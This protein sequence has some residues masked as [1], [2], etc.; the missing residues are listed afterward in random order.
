MPEETPEQ[1][2]LGIVEDRDM[3]VCAD[4]W[5]TNGPVPTEEICP[6]CDRCEDCCPCIVCSSCSDRT[7]NYCEECNHC[8]DCCDCN[9]CNDCGRTQNSVCSGCDR[10]DGCGCEC[11]EES[12]G[13]SLIDGRL[14]FHAARKDQYKLN[15]SKRFISLE[16]E[17]SEGDGQSVHDTCMKYSDAIV[18]DGSLP[19]SGWELNMNPSQGD[20]FVEHCNDIAKG[21]KIGEACVDSSCGMHCHVDARDYGWFDLFKLIKLYSIVENG[22]FSIVSPSRKQGQYSKPCRDLFSSCSNF[23]TFKVDLMSALYDYSV[24]V[25]GKRKSQDGNSHIYFTNYNS[26]K[27]HK[28]S[29]GSP[30]V[31]AARS[32]KYNGAR[33]SALNIHSYFYRGTIE[34]RHHQGTTQASKMIH[35]GRICAAVIDSATKMSLKEI[36]NLNELTSFDALLSILSDD[37]KTWAMPRKKD[38][39]AVR[40]S[41][42]RGE[43]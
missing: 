5:H 39:E 3:S 40:G 36:A 9:H 12:N 37:L 1:L 23:K 29:H 19:D 28:N 8:N 26:G 13:D 2:E 20:V 38:M 21:L 41:D 43:C 25:K 22:M 24:P 18:E 32:E 4:R 11:D 33:Y 42:R 10:C 30:K 27:A 15:P 7:Q 6:N 14:K 31:L 16:V 35:W 34:F 17:V